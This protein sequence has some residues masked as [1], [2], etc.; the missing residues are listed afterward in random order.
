MKAYQASY[1]IAM[2]CRLLDVST[3]GYHAWR[4]QRPSR[5]AVDDAALTVRIA[6]IHKASDRTYGS[7][8]TMPSSAMKVPVSAASGSPV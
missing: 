4:H 5:R 6:E 8:R 1:P 2:M 3:S 7:P